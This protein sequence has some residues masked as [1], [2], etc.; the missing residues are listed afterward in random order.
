MKPE[1][2]KTTIVNNY[3]E[4]IRK[5]R[6]TSTKLLIFEE[7]CLTHFVVNTPI[8]SSNIGNHHQQHKVKS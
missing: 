7:T 2:R 5:I 1:F 8:S 3:K 6:A 4:Y